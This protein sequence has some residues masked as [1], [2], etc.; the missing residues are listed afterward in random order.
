MKPDIFTVFDVE[1]VASDGPP[2]LRLA[3][4]LDI[5]TAGRFRQALCRAHDDGV[6]TWSSTCRG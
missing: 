3:G 2:E 6:A 4:E 1:M 5:G